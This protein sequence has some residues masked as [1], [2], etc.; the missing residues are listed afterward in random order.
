MLML[1]VVCSLYKL[2]FLYLLTT[3]KQQT[4]DLLASVPLKTLVM[5]LLTRCL[6]STLSV[7]AMTA[8]RPIPWRP[9]TMT[10]TRCTMMATAMKTWKTNGVLLR[11]RQIHDVKLCIWSSWFVPVVV[12]AV[13]VIVCGR[14]GLW[15]SWFVAVMVCGQLVWAE[16]SCVCCRF[17]VIFPAVQQ[18]MRK[19][20]QCL[21]VSVD[22]FVIRS[23]VHNVHLCLILMFV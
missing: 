9:Q 19:R 3:Y 14:H 22:N 17:G 8:S 11:N 1:P 21:Q 23:R 4:Y 12:V 7:V 20:E 6:I 18:A 5:F 16:C 13:M 2:F 10:A 15:P